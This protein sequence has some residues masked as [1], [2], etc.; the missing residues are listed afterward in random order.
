LSVSYFQLIQVLKYSGDHPLA[1]SPK[2]TQ[3]CDVRH[4]SR[5][6]APGWHG[7]GQLAS[8]AMPAIRTL[9]RVDLVSR[10]NRLNRWEVR[11]LM[12]FGI[13]VVTAEFRTAIAARP[14]T[15]MY[16]PVTR[17]RRNQRA[18]AFHMPRL[19]PSFASGFRLCRAHWLLSRSVARRWQRRI[20]RVHAKSA[21]EFLE[22]SHQHQK[23]GACRRTALVPRLLRNTVWFDQRSFAHTRRMS[24]FTNS[25]KTRSANGYDLREE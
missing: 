22:L 7:R 5:P 14:G 12:A 24:E 1:E 17:F 18:S 21:L 8:I 11:N 4:D 16:H 15:M 6:K 20:P 10:D 19:T 23:T 25:E 3:Q 9:K 2:T 13:R